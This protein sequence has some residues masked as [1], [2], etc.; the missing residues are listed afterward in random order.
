MDEHHIDVRGAAQHRLYI[1]HQGP[2]HIGGDDILIVEGAFLGGLF[3][4]ADE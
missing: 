4:Y 2:G 1:R 3:G